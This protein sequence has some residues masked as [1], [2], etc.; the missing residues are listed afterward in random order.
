MAQLLYRGKLTFS[1]LVPGLNSAAESLRDRTDE[2]DEFLSERQKNVSALQSK[3]SRVQEELQKAQD[4]AFNAQ[5]ILSAANA[6]LDEAKGLTDQLADALSASGI[7]HYNYVGRV[8][9]MGGQISAEFFDG[10]PDRPPGSGE[11]A[12]AVVILMVGGDGGVSA[13]LDRIGSLFG[14]I[15]DNATDIQARYSTEVGS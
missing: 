8:D 12:V 15:G 9:S 5:G 4:T 7:Y 1:D 11:E 13:T 6:I 10:L 14:Q 2:L 3:V